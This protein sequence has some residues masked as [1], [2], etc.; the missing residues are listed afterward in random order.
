MP[1]LYVIE[2]KPGTEKKKLQSNMKNAPNFKGF[3]YENHQDKEEKLA[4]SFGIVFFPSCSVVH[5]GGAIL[6]IL[7]GL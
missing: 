4:L 5:K 7:R 3:M 6:L 2:F 1:K